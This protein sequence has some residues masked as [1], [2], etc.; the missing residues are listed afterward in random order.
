MK[1]S[2]VLS[3][4]ALTAT[5]AFAAPVSNESVDNASVP[6]E[7]IIGYLNFDGANDI[8]LLPFSNSTTSGVMFINTT[9]AEQAYEEAGVSLSKREADAWHWLRLDPGQPLYKRDAEAD[10]EAWH[11]LRLDPGQP[12]YKR[13]AEADA[14]AWHWLRLDPGQ[15][16][17]K[18]DAE[19]DAEAWHWLRL[20]P[21]QPLY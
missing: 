2:S 17:Y 12:L 21:G 11:W 9:I 10:A 19:A 5:S 7:A 15:P 3:T 8:A 14:E 18:R 16:L 6:A 20:D 13:D 1:L 4:L